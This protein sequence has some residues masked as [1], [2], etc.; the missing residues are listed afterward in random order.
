MPMR[1]KFITYGVY[2]L[3]RWVLAVLF[4]YSGGTKLLDPQSFAVII[5][6]FGLVPEILIGPIAIGLP[7]LEIIVA[8]GLFFDIRG[9]MAVITVL[10]VLFIA[11][12]G[13]AIYMGLDIDCGCFGPNDP[14]AEAFHSLHLALWRNV[15]IMAGIIFLYIWRLKRSDK[16]KNVIYFFKNI[17]NQKGEMI[18]ESK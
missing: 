10:I 13:Y 6:A 17:F 12:L 8:F 11:I 7:I 5:D 2:R 14:E 15:V 9:A 4:L 18:N 16:P 1:N 3:F